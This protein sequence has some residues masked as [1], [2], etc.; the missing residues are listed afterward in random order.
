MSEC[1]VAWR[2][3]YFALLHESPLLQKPWCIMIE[4]G[5]TTQLSERTEAVKELKMKRCAENIVLSMSDR[6]CNDITLLSHE[7]EEAMC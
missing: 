2:N 4:R 6:T 3:R 1:D 7:E 5:D